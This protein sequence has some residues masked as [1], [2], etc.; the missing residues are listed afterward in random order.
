VFWV[1]KLACMGA[2]HR[3]RRLLYHNTSL[4]GFSTSIFRSKKSE[5]LEPPN[6]KWL[7]SSYLNPLFPCLER[8]RKEIVSVSGLLRPS[9][10]VETRSSRGCIVHYQHSKQQFP[11]S[12]G[13]GGRSW[14]C[15][16]LGNLPS[17]LPEPKRGV[18]IIILGYLSIEE[19][20]MFDLEADFLASRLI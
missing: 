20:G 16:S 11:C 4:A 10:P 15:H 17:P 18:A 13:R 3:S 12:K 14:S 7:G 9:T 8:A 5:R 6:C 19:R 2:R 1:H